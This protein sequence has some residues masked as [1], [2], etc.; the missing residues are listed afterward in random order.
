VFAKALNITQILYKIQEHRRNW[1]QLVNCLS[2][3]RVPRI[4]KN[5]DHKAEEPGDTIKQT[6]KRVRPERVNMWPNVC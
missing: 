2:R 1:L 3:D 4:L 6:S 5:T